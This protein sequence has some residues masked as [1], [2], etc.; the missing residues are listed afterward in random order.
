MS[1]SQVPTVSAVRARRTP[2]VLVPKV[3]PTKNPRGRKGK[4]GWNAGDRPLQKNSLSNKKRNGTA[5]LFK[6]AAELEG[7]TDGQYR[8]YVVVVDTTTAADPSMCGDRNH[9]GPAPTMHIYASGV[10]GAE[11]GDKATKAANKIGAVVKKYANLR[12]RNDRK[13][14]WKKGKRTA[15]VYGPDAARRSPA[16]SAQLALQSFVASQEQ[17]DNEELFEDELDDVLASVPVF[18]NGAGTCGADGV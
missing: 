6:K 14:K 16:A 1:A 18:G 8:C 2:N 3:Q 11:D 9:E 4:A 7:A 13:S 10:D 15:K 17:E 12:V 5:T